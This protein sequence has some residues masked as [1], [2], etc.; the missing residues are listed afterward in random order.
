MDLAAPEPLVGD[1]PNVLG[2]YLYSLAASI[3][4]GTSEIQRTLIAERLLHL[5]RGR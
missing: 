5:P 3:Y 2:D 4:G 1:R